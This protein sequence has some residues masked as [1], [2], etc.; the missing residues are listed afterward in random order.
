MRRYAIPLG[1]VSIMASLLLL[2][3]MM[4]IASQIAPEWL[5]AFAVVTVVSFLIANTWYAVRENR[6]R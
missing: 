5:V 4:L 2:M 6:Q 1:I 3:A